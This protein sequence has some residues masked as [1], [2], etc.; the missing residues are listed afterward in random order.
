MTGKK[1]FGIAGWKNSGKTSLVA[2]LVEELT[3]RG[4]VVST[5]KHAHH[6][7]DLDREGTDS[8]RHRQ[9]GSREVVLVSANRWAVQHELAGE[10]EPSLDHFLERLSPCDLVLVEGYKYAAIPKLEIIGPDS[11][12]KQLLWQ[13][14]P[15]IRA[16]ASDMPPENCSLPHF[17]RQD[18]S[19][20]ADF[21]LELNGLTS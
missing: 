20:I 13:R 15:D 19:A 1:C 8:F 12:K 5:I 4:F 16:I 10:D 17:Q 11:L 18:V 6:T 7:F 9:A 21:I 3:T 2:G 14:D